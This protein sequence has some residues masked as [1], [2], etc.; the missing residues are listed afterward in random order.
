MAPKFEPR[1]RPDTRT[2]ILASLIRLVLGLVSWLG[3][4]KYLRRRPQRQTP[5]TA[6]RGRTV[7]A[8]ETF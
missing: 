5:K 7:G 8:R 3:L 4:G 2:P 6:R 1:P